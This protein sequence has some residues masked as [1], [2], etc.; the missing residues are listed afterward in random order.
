M[1]GL[2]TQPI[3]GAMSDRTWSVKTA[4]EKPYFFIGAPHVASAFALHPFQQ[5]TVDGSGASLDSDV[6]NNTAM[7]PY[8]AFIADT[9]NTDQQTDGISGAKF[10]Y[11]IRSDIG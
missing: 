2:L 1:T 10:F 9:L 8:R 11:R 7:E 6:G 5:H 4:E 3:I